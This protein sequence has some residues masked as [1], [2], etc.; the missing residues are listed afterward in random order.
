[1]KPEPFGTRR[2]SLRYP[3]VFAARPDHN[4][5]VRRIGSLLIGMLVTLCMG[6]V[7]KAHDPIILTDDQTV[8]EAG[9]FLPDGTIS[10]A[11][12]GSFGGAGETRGLRAR[13]V[14][15]DRLHV[16]LLIP[17]LAPE[18]AL[19]D[20]ELPRLEI[21]EPGGEVTTLVPDL[22]RKFAEPF[23]GTNYIELIDLV[24]TASEGIYSITVIGG[25]AARFT[26]SVGDTETFGTPVEGVTDRAAGING[27]M[28]WYE[29][30][31]LAEVVDTSEPSSTTGE[32][33]GSVG[34]DQD[35]AVTS[36]QTTTDEPAKSGRQIVV[37]VVLVALSF[38]VWRISRILR[39]RSRR[40]S[41]Q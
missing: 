27:V 26:V 36:Q 7:A 20:S 9:P 1:M 3:A 21:L 35:Y 32:S 23:T 5:N 28:E 8:P 15:G 10:F 24:G 34:P 41:P 13:F 6:S 4:C 33:Q 30:D 25:E 17:D 16:S 18:N 38:G 22:R 40:S 37:V 2:R 14:E 12:Y 29:G 31:N 19:S 11:L 39:D